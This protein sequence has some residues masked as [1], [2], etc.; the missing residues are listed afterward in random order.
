MREKVKS[1]QI[2]PEGAVYV[3]SDMNM[4]CGES[5]VRQLMYGKEWY[6]KEFG[7]DS[8]VAWLPDTFGFSG[9]LPQLLKQCGIPYFATQKLV[10]QDPEC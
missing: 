9:A 10:R 4:P 8:R 5:L 1:G 7:V 3:E 6:R 2:I